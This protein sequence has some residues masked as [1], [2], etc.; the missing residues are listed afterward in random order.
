MCLEKVIQEATVVMFED[1]QARH[2]QAR[3][4]L[5]KSELTKTLESLKEGFS[6]VYIINAG[7]KSTFDFQSPRP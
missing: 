2:A 7:D 4:V 1:I 5:L 3:H 6:T